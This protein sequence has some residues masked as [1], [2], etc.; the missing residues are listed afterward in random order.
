MLFSAPT[1]HVFSVS[2]SGFGQGKKIPIPII[3]PIINRL[4]QIFSCEQLEFYIRGSS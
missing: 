2:R 4:P 3:N 1:G